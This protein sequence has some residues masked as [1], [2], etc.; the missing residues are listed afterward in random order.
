[1]KRYKTQENARFQN[2]SY[3]TQIDRGTAKQK[4]HTR[5]TATKAGQWRICQVDDG[6]CCKERNNV[7]FD[8]ENLI[9]GAF[10]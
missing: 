9:S 8:G 10:P 3:N 1:M 2:T 7:V 4:D 6:V 5:P